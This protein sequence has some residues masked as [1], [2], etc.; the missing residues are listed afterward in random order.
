VEA[1]DAHRIAVDGV[2]VRYVDAHGGPNVVIE[3]SADAGPYLVRRIDPHGQR[4]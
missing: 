2:T 3:G 1:R 4:G